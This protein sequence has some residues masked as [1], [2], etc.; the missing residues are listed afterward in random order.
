MPSLLP[1]LNLLPFPRSV[2]LCVYALI[3]MADYH[4]TVKSPANKNVHIFGIRESKG[5]YFRGL[6]NFRGGGGGGG[7][8]LKPHLERRLF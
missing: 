2:E 7:F 5:I 3:L 1:S 6:T 4:V 8:R